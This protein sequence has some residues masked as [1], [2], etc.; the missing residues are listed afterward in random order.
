MRP[1]SRFHA[2]SVLAAGIVL[3]LLTGIIT[4]TLLVISIFV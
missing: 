3:I 1:P 2:P 4:G